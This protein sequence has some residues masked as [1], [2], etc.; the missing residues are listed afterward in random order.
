MLTFAVAAVVWPLTLHAITIPTV[1]VGHPNNPADRRY[2][3]T[4]FGSVSYALR[5][6]NW[7]VTNRQYA[8]FLNSVAA[9]DPYFLYDANMG[10]SPHGGI[11]R[12]GSH[13]NFTYYLGRLGFS[14]C[15]GDS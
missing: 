6:S 5:M 1:I 9:S 14:G 12:S 11:N 3:A 15:P 8:A 13:G 10:S 4:G 2:S 7:E